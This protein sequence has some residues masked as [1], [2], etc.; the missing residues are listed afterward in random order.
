MKP[1][2]YQQEGIDFLRKHR[3]AY[4][5]DDMGLGKTMQL[6]RASEGKTL[7]VAPAT[8]VASG[9][10]AREIEKWS[11]DPSRFEVVSYSKL[12]PHGRSAKGAA[13]ALRDELRQQWD[14]VIFDE[15]HYL[16]NRNAKRTKAA[17]VLQ[18]RY[19]DRVYLASGTPVS[20]WSHE[21]FVP[22]QILQPEEAVAGGRLGSYWRWVESWFRVH[23]SPFA[24]GTL[25]IGKLKGCTAECK[26]RSL[27]DPCEHYRRFTSENFQGQFIRR[28]RDEVLTE[29]PPIQ[30]QKV[31]IPMKTNQWKQYRAMR[32]DFLAEVD[33]D[34]VV[35]W[36]TGG[37]HVL[38]DRICTSLGMLGDD[39]MK[40]SNKMDQLAED[41]QQRVR[42]TV[43][44]AHYRDTVEAAA[45]VAMD[46]GKT[47]VVI[48][49]GIDSATRGESIRKFTEGKVDVL[50]GSFET[51]SEGLT[52]TISDCII[53]VEISY[54]AA[55]NAQ[56]V[57]RIN[58]IGQDRKC[59]VLEYISTGPT[60]QRCLD[61][62]KRDRIDE[63]VRDQENTMSAA[64]FKG[65]I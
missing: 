4:L 25:E 17:Q 41:L 42:P 16:K 50:V 35:A 33:N 59:L 6:I 36:S 61:M 48:H 26:Q 44:V 7:V 43:V 40:D 65:L 2:Q 39:S 49:G 32:K 45:Q 47:A 19:A 37:R 31:K 52:L 14:T 56:V 62:S 28:L 24:R 46:Q 8:L 53:M 38:M 57:R 60:G 13:G 29:L 12:H 63:K 58:R 5:A 11:D 3:R 20:N 34:A 15:A 21:L 55:R 18:R 10:W 64:H 22:L 9:T 1:Y 51:I 23:D 54:K 30:H 27:D